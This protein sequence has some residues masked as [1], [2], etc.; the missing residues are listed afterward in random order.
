[1]PDDVLKR[2]ENQESFFTDQELYDNVPNHINND[3][4]YYSRRIVDKT[5]VKYYFEII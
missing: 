4:S 1:M 5:N 2:T 3:N